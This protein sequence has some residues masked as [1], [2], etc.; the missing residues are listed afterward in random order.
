M[1]FM[2]LFSG[3]ARRA[4]DHID[5]VFDAGLSVVEDDFRRGEIDDD[6]RFDVIEAAPRSSR[7]S[8]LSGRHRR[9]HRHLRRH[10]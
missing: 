5:T 3:Q 7:M 8:V 1:E 10:E 9:C 2:T 4:D 6:I